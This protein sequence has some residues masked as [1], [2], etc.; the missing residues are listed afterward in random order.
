MNQMHPNSL[1]TRTLSTLLERIE[2][3]DYDDGM[4]PHDKMCLQMNISRTAFRE[5]I[6]ILRFCNV[7]S[8]TPKVGTKVNPRGVWNKALLRERPEVP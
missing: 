2:A 6:V 5:A 1:V 4:P 3:G 7:I 8:V